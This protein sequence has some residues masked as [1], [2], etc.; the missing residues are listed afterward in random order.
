[1]IMPPKIVQ[2]AI[3]SVCPDYYTWDSERQEIWR[4]NLRNDTQLYK[5]FKNYLIK[6]GLGYS[7]KKTKKINNIKKR[8]RIPIKDLNRLNE[9][10]LW[11]IGVGENYIYLNEEFPGDKET[12]LEYA[13][14]R[15]LDE[16]EHIQQQLYQ[17]R[18]PK[19]YPY[20]PNLYSSWIRFFDE[21]YKI[22]Y[23]SLTMA[24]TSLL[25][26]IER[27][28]DD[29]LDD[30]IPSKFING[31][32]HGTK[33]KNGHTLWNKVIFADGKEDL[34]KNMKSEFNLYQQK[35]SNDYFVLFNEKFPNI[36]WKKDIEHT[37]DETSTVLIFSNVDVLEKIRYRYFV[38]D[39]TNLQEADN[40]SYDSILKTECEELTVW[41][42]K[43]LEELTKTS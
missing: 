36:T 10:M 16:M 25:E 35:K 31:P 43:T 12:L 5:D 37:I 18:A 23:C 1:M 2:K 24:Q 39:F 34:L 22:T 40:T 3:L 6:K 9:W 19:D 27:A 41:F 8:K 15:D 20:V 4:A 42:K 32:N 7:D 17:N 30:A 28:F 29:L 33:N 26:D 14:V 13:T 11:A 21:D 38:K